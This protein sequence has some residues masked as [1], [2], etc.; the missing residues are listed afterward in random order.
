MEPRRFGRHGFGRRSESG[1][2]PVLCL[3][4]RCYI[5][6]GAAQPARMMSRAQ[7]L[8]P[9]NT[10]GGRAGACRHSLGCVFRDVELGSTSAAI[11][12]IDLNLFRHDRRQPETVRA[13]ATCAAG[14]HRLQCEEPVHGL[15]W[16]AWII[17]ED[18]ADR[19]GPELLLDAIEDGLPDQ[20]SASL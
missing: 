9:A 12:P 14:D 5:S 8:G 17:P 4:N 20:R 7:A 11:Q 6:A 2:D 15:G 19:A 18:I 16:R 3:G 1:S 10:L 13:D